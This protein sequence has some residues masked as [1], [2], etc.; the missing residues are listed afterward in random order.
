MKETNVGIGQDDVEQYLGSIK[1]D[2]I[3]CG[4]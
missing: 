4:Q 3:K 2:K 1:T